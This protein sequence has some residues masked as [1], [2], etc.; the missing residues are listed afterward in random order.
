MRRRLLSPDSYFLEALSV[1]QGQRGTASVVPGRL[2]W[3]HSRMMCE[4]WMVIKL[5]CCNVAADCANVKRYDCLQKMMR[6][7]ETMLTSYLAGCFD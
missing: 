4:P 6:V 7:V 1:E 2:R 3:V 5:P